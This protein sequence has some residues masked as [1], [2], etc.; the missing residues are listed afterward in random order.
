MDTPQALTDGFTARPCAP[1]DLDAVFRMVSACEMA[2]A[3]EVTIELEDVQSEWAR[4]SFDLTT[5]TIAVFED[6][7]GA[8]VAHGEVTYGTRADACVHPDWRG[9]TIGTWLLRWTADHA[10]ARGAMR[11]GQTVPDTAADAINLFERNGYRWLWTSWILQI[12]FDDGPPA[13]PEVPEGYAIRDFIPGTDDRIVAALID[14]A[15]LEWAE[16]DPDPFE[17][18]AARTIARPRFVPWHLPVMTGPGDEIVAAAFLIDPEDVSEGWVQQLAVARDHR[19]RGL[20][21]ALLAESFHRFHSRGA[22]ACGVNTDSRTGALGLYEHV[23]MSVRL[24][25]THRALHFDAN[26]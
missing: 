23:G 19:S 3:G 11:I 13:A 5:D 4:P 21:R 20:A 6:S 9:R 2:D 1:E 12:R 26:A 17:D 15:F 22:A 10:R 8:L 18:W 7:S 24:S 16:R 14:T 25:Y